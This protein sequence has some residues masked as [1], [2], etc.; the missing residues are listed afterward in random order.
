V[1]I[2]GDLRKSLIWTKASFSN[3]GGACVEVAQISDGVA[4]R[5]SKDPEGSI[6]RYTKPEWSAF[7]SGVRAGEFD[8]FL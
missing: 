4:V 8:R 2:P 5:D 3:P 7:L 1:D 6:L